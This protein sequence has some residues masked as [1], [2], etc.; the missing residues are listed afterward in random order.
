MCVCVRA[1]ACVRVCVGRTRNGLLLPVTRRQ[2]PVEQ[3]EDTA[4]DS[5]LPFVLGFQQRENCPRRVHHLRLWVL[6]VLAGDAR[7]KRLPPP[8]IPAWFQNFTNFQFSVPGSK[9]SKTPEPPN[10][11]AKFRAKFRNTHSFCF[12]TKKLQARFTASC[13]GSN[14]W[15]SKV[16][17]K[18]P[19]SGSISS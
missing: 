4:F 2:Q 15:K 6:H 12:E 1:S 8:A 7:H 10:S 16:G 18:S 17:H 5:R 14:P 3:E 9:N 13:S 11:R 19:I